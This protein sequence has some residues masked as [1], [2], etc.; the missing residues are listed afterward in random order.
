[1]KGPDE[2]MEYLL[3]Q[4]M[5]RGEGGLATLIVMMAYSVIMTIII[6]IIIAVH[7]AIQNWT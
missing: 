4:S 2:W 7:E 3:K 1:M 6:G 5:E